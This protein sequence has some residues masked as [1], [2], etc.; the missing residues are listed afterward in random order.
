MAEKIITRDGTIT[1][2]CESVDETYHS[3]SG[4]EEEAREKYA[5]LIEQHP[6]KKDEIVIYDVCFGL[7]Y[8]TAA[9]IDEITEKKTRFYCFEVDKEILSK[10]P[11]INPSFKSYA[12]IKEFTHNFLA[13]Q[14]TELITPNTEIRMVF[15]K[16]E[17]RVNEMREFADYVLFDPFSPKKNPELW[18]EEVFKSVYNKM[19]DESYLFTYSCARQVRE[20]MKKAGFEVLDGP[21]IGRRSPS[22]IAKKLIKQ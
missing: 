11:L 13:K 6:I 16:F 4:A 1:F 20:N 19:T 7:G 14:E 22:T 17:D 10:I 8:N 15:G 9:T 3:M 5:K 18:S 12:L 21:I 2:R